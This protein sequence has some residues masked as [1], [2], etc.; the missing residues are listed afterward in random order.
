[1]DVCCSTSVLVHGQVGPET[2][3]ISQGLDPPCQHGSALGEGLG[4]D[5]HLPSDGAVARLHMNLDEI[6][7]AHGPSCSNGKANLSLWLSW[8]TTAFTHSWIVCWVWS[9]NIKYIS[10]AFWCFD[11]GFCFLLLEFLY[12]V[13]ALVFWSHLAEQQY[14]LS[15]ALAMLQCRNHI[16]RDYFVGFLDNL[17]L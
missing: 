9:F 7:A 14:L 17:S 5:P 11:G 12:E 1:M 8:F 10:F 13:S 6:Q 4:L 2:T 15:G 16:P 3:P